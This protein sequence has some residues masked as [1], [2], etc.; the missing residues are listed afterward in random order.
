[1]AES[2]DDFLAGWASG[3]VALVV[4]Q[5]LDLFITRLQSG[6][7]AAK[8]AAASSP[9]VLWRGTWPVLLVQP[10]NSA[11]LFLGYGEGVRW[12]EAAS[13]RRGDSATDAASAALLP[14]FLGGCAGGAAQS[15]VQSPAEMLKVR[16]QLA[17]ADASAGGAA[18][19]GAAATAAGAGAG[20][21]A[22][23][24]PLLAELMR[25][26]A[27]AVVPP[28]LSRGL[29]ATLARDVV[30]HGVWFASYERCKQWLSAD[31]SRSRTAVELA[32]GAAAAVAAWVVGYPADVLKTRCQMADGPPT[33]GAAAADVYAAE[34]L[35]GFY[36]GLG[37][38]LCR[39]VPMSAMGFV[40]YEEAI[41][42]LA[43]VRGESA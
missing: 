21:R 38:K 33:L 27:G 7:V 14:V 5:P 42:A 32:S 40:V 34:G 35:G 1:M 15:F 39:A 17:A 19:A 4:T 30:P 28:L 10:V 9:A 22:W 23:G 6:G 16:L 8:A 37:L 31:S 36:R 29:A 3:A 18:A 11:L 26:A 25:P 12:A 41:R 2:V 20:A 43:R 13:A 24:L